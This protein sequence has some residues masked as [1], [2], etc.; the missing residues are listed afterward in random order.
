ML[1]EIHAH[2]T[3]TIHVHVHAPA[4]TAPGEIVDTMPTPTTIP[5]EPVPVGYRMPEEID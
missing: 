5:T 1:I 2:N 3:A 4:E